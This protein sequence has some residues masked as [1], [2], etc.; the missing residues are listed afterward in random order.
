MSD[1]VA[2]LRA[3]LEHDPANDSLRLLLADALV[4]A[5]RREEAVT[6]YLVLASA[7][8]LSGFE[9]TAAA[10]LAAAA[11]TFSEASRLLD[12]AR[13][14]GAV[15][16]VADVQHTID[17]LLG[18]AGVARELEVH[19]PLTFVDVGGLAEVKDT[20][21]MAIIEPLRDPELFQRFGRRVGGGVLLYGPP[22][23]GKTL[24]AHATAAEAERPFASIRI[25]DILNPFSGES[26]RRLHEAFEEARRLAPSVLVIDEIDSIGYARARTGILRRTLVDQ[27]L[28]ELDDL[29]GVLVIGTTNTPWDVDEAVARAG[30]FDTQSF[31]A[32]P[33]EASRRA[34]LELHLANK[35]VGDIDL[36]RVAAKTKLFSGADL[37]A[38][39]RRAA[40]AALRERSDSIEHRHLEVALR[41][42]RAT[43]QAWISTARR[44]VEFANREGRWDDVSA[45]VTSNE[46]RTSRI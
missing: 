41:S 17:A 15:D 23:C 20:L 25:N 3:A 14:A 1:H 26:E 5:G 29:D 37:A 19:R 18:L 34:I 45:Y 27:L 8:A 33:D 9:L 46:A 12:A 30:R 10:G 36:A 13:A 28:H 40:E 42:A 6:E 38:V 4:T 31:V 2:A 24:I 35:P 21:R 11:G 39:V 7:G 22:G 16:G 44:Y 43:T 32:P